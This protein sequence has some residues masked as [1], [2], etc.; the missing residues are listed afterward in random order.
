MAC[1]HENI[2][3]V[4]QHNYEVF[5]CSEESCGSNEEVYEKHEEVEYHDKED[6]TCK[7]TKENDRQEPDG[8]VI[9]KML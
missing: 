6:G 1:N 7:F 4:L 5:Q 2:D 3:E 8:K 9:I